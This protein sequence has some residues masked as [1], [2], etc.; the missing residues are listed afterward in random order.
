MQQKAAP[1]EDKRKKIIEKERELSHRKAEKAVQE[2]R[3]AKVMA[4]ASNG[5][6]V[7]ICFNLQKTL[8][9]PSLTTN[10]VYYLRTLW[11]YNFCIHDLGSKKAHMYVWDKANAGRG[12]SEVASCLLKF[13]QQLP[14]DT[15]KN[16]CFQ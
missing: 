16:Y 15:K 11:T 14:P 13:E 5:E 1:N 2:K 4:Q 10:K 8:A 7:A 12:S 3:N 9:T 6:I